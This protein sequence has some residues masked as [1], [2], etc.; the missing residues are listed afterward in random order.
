MW[1]LNLN[2][3]RIVACLIVSILVGGLYYGIFIEPYDVMV[4]KVTIRDDLLYKAW[5]GL[6]ILQLSD[7]H[8][9]NIGKRERKVRHLVSRLDPDLICV[10]GD[11]AQWD[12]SNSKVIQ[13]L[14]SLKAKYGVYVILGDSDM[15]TGSQRCFFCH[16]S[17]NIHGLRRKPVFLRNSLVQVQIKNGRHI[18]I[19]GIAP[20]LNK[21]EFP[22]FWKGIEMSFDNYTPVLVLSHF[23]SLWN[24]VPE[25]EH[26]LWLSGDT[27]GGQVA[28]PRFLWPLVYRGKDY[29]HLK[30][31][32]SSGE[33]K[34]LYVNQGIGTTRHLPVRIGVPP[35]ITLFSFAPKIKRGSSGT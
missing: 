26:L 11:L 13:F 28:L 34:W 5:H 27:H 25:D 8:I 23:S 20:D 10:T 12:S 6:K 32:F 14:N 18:E 3:K 16:K 19:I 17:G 1:T 9:T 22:V 21:E 7:L 24:L 29:E 30:G 31:L 33:G 15:S 35:E 2:K 4:K